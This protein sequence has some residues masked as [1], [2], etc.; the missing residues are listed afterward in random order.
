[1]I[2]N[3]GNALH[4][5][6]SQAIDQRELVQLQAIV[7]VDTLSEHFLAQVLETRKLLLI[8]KIVVTVVH[9]LLLIDHA[10]LR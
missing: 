2:L 4:F 9:G 1:M 6:Y 7:H 3:D 5:Q 10:V 8:Q